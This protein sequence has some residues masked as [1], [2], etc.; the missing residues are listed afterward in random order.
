MAD[1]TPGEGEGEDGGA[2]QVGNDPDYDIHDDPTIPRGGWEPDRIAGIEGFA[3]GFG[4]DGV[5]GFYHTAYLVAL[6]DGEIPGASARARDDAR[7]VLIPDQAEMRKAILSQA[8]MG[9]SVSLEMARMHQFQGLFEHVSL[10]PAVMPWGATSLGCLEPLFAHLNDYE[11]SGTLARVCST[12]RAAASIWRAVTTEQQTFGD[13]RFTQLHPNAVRPMPISVGQMLG[14]SITSAARL[15]DAGLA[16]LV[17][18][19]PNLEKLAVSIGLT[20]KG[21][22]RDPLTPGGLQRLTALTHLRYLHVGSSRPYIRA[23]YFPKELFEGSGGHLTEEDRQRMRTDP[24]DALEGA[25]AAEALRAIVSGCASLETL[26]LPDTDSAALCALAA[27]P[28]GSLRHLRVGLGA[29]D[30]AIDALA[31]CAL[32]LSSLELSCV[33]STSSEAWGRLVRSKPNVSLLRI[34]VVPLGRAGGWQSF[35]GKGDCPMPHWRPLELLHTIAA[36]CAGLV[37]LGVRTGERWARWANGLEESDARDRDR[38]GEPALPPP[39]LPPTSDATWHQDFVEFLA[40]DGYES[41]NDC[42][43][44]GQ[45]D[46]SGE[47]FGRRMKN[48]KHRELYR[49]CAGLA[50]QCAAHRPSNSAART[51]APAARSARPSP[52]PDPGGR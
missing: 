32:Q 1:N 40:P 44:E 47:E 15:G 37:L 27:A 12:W 5:C 3:G 10:P 16:A 50:M 4:I 28:S 14:S 43:L 20:R 38:R 22:A 9:Y 21:P 7:A 24:G 41:L 26:I 25:P 8:E 35:T 39:P 31:G 36:H 48:F 45:S 34:E 52:D 51:L 29:C 6:A 33:A 23:Q 2:A 42:S 13:R 19:C 18:D 30:A 49:H 11:L 17:R 46:M